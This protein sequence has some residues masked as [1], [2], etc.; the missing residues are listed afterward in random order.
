MNKLP[1]WAK[2]LAA[3]VILAALYG[4]TQVLIGLD[5]TAGNKAGLD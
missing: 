5:Q 2:V 3:I 1:A 4:G